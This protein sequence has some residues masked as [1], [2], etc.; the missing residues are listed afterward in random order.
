MPQ[1]REATVCMTSTFAG[2]L[3]AAI[4][5]VGLFYFLTLCHVDYALSQE[6]PLEAWWLRTSFPADQSSYAGLDVSE[7]NPRWVKMGALSYDAMPAEAHMDYPWM[8]SGGFEFTKEGHLSHAGSIE[9]A[10]T[11]VYKDLSGKGGRFLL[12]LRKNEIGKWEKVFLHEEP[13]EPGFSV[14]R[15]RGRSL[16]WGTCLQCGDFRRLV[17]GPSNVGLE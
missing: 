4:A 8:R 2:R 16:Y 11:G 12:V 6:K 7:I 13:G 1:S 3:K 17:V 9:R 5:L 10:V 15:S 14:L